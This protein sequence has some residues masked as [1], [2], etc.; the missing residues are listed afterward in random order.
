MTSNLIKTTN[1]CW[2]QYPKLPFPQS[3]TQGASRKKARDACIEASMQGK[4]DPELWNGPTILKDYAALWRIP[5]P[6]AGRPKDKAGGVIRT[7][8]RISDPAGILPI[9]SGGELVRQ[10]AIGWRP[11]TGMGQDRFGELEQKATIMGA[12]DALAHAG[13]Q[14]YVQMQAQLEKLPELKLREDKT[15]QPLLAL[16]GQK[17]LKEAAEKLR[18]VVIQNG[19]EKAAWL[20][21]GIRLGIVA[22]NAQ[23]KRQ[24]V[25]TAVSTATFVAGQA[26]NGTFIGAVVGVPLTAVSA[27]MAGAS[28]RSGIE[29]V[30]SDGLIKKYTAELENALA[31]RNI[32]I[33]QQIV[34]R[35]LN[36]AE[37]QLAMIQSSALAE[38]EQQARYIK[39]GIGVV[40]IG[41]AGLSSYL[42]VRR[43]KS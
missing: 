34:D 32:E 22:K 37:A 41:L 10:M 12:L 15:E 36:K 21:R 43:L 28:G 8:G 20:S 4:P 38:G 23:K 42:I 27:T 18:L 35:Q 9:Q 40:A 13:I 33:K 39:Y 26:L 29:K 3:I 2:Q 31:T 25:E 30:R 1:E 24:M 19:L 17:S 14:P 11:L 16:L 7:I 6:W 5:E